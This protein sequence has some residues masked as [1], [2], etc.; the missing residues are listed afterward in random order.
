MVIPKKCLVVDSTHSNTVLINLHKFSSNPLLYML[1]CVHT[2]SRNSCNGWQFVSRRAQIPGS[3]SRWTAAIRQFLGP[4]LV[5]APPQ[6]LHGR[7]DSS[8]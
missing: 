5:S 2:L 8:Q 1:A 4:P 6:R 3:P 7:S